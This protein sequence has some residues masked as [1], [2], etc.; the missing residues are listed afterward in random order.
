M[1]NSDLYASVIV[2][3]D[4][5]AVDKAFIYSI[6]KELEEKIKIGDKVVFPFGKGDKE[7]EGF[8]ISIDTK[9]D[10]KNSEK[11]EENTYLKDD[12]S[13]EKAKAIK[14]IAKNKLPVSNLLMDIALFL[15]KEYLAPMSSCLKTVLPVK[16]ELRNNKRR[17]DVL[18]KYEKNKINKPILN[19]EQKRIIND[20]KEDL[21]TNK[22]SNH[23]LYGIT[24]SGKTEVFLNV[25]EE[26]INK[27]KQVIVL[28]PEIS[29]TYQT[30]IRL[31]ERF[32]DNVGII[33]SS[34]SEGEKYI[35]I[36]KCINGEIK[37]LVGPRSAVFAPF[38]NLGLIVMDEEDDDSYKS[39]LTPRY[40]AYTVAKYRCEKQ[41]A[42]F[43][44]LS[45]TPRL[46]HFYEAKKGDNIKL[47]KLT[48]RA[49]D[50]LSLPETHIVDLRNEYKIGNKNIFSKLLIEKINERLEKK[51][52]VLLFMNRRGYNK[53][54]TCIECGETIKCPHCD[55]PL[56]FHADGS[57]KCH[58]CGYTT[59]DI[60]DCPNCHSKKLNAFGIG[61]EK[62]ESKT[63]ELFK[64]AK[65]LRMDRDT[66]IKKDS[67]DEII[68]KFNNKEADILIG[69][70]MIVK[71][72]DFSN[73]TL[74]A[75]MCADMS[76][77]VDTFNATEKAF[78]LLTQMSGRSGRKKKGECIIQTY[79]PENFA[80]DIVKNADYEKFYEKE[81]E[82]RK[83]FNFPPIKKLLTITIK[84]LVEE[85]VDMFSKDLS[86]Y[87][88]I[89]ND[90][91]IVLGP[92][93]PSPSKIKDN[94]FRN[95]YI[96]CDNI[97][98]AKDIRKKAYD[99]IRKKDQKR[100]IMIIFDID[101]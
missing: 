31:R 42:M 60:K 47:H 75:I 84:S 39:E 80:I 43:L 41:N 74:V 17:I 65:I 16:R 53:T 29:L 34:M 92:I 23:L 70:Q 50:D 1:T 51:E 94:Y 69:T 101:E 8:V 93:I 20:L 61:T 40:D 57:M 97:E 36:K 64:N 33:N 32:S 22:F 21:K 66:V 68:K 89:D 76:L 52:Q 25:I 27:N 87:L 85:V 14:N 4:S 45:A 73:V 81:I 83:N 63:K 78:S 56:T 13:Y 99:Y 79:D 96:K 90:K 48:K 9:E 62:L 5:D 7:K 95:I 49:V 35:Q 28:I 86:H 88:K 71:G 38:E 24:G 58:Y 77:N 37:I 30:M 67:Y 18:E 72:H 19:E 55:V 54:L 2:D 91:N 46:S 59:F 26:V 3:I 6:P 15:S 44:S 82:F 100:E 11:A 98:Y 12:K 10:L